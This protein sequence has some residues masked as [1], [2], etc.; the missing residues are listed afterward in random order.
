[1]SARAIP[2]RRTWVPDLMAFALWAA[3]QG[4]LTPCAV[5]QRFGVSRAT[6][7]RWIAAFNEARLRNEPWPV[8]A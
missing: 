5:M 7:F 8:A 6:A 1:M 2:S 3:K 4:R